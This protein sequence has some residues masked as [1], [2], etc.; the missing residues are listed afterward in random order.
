MKRKN[1]TILSIVVLITLLPLV[2]FSQKNREEIDEKYKWNLNDIYS[3]EEEWNTAKENLVNELP[4]LETFKGKLTSS[5]SDLLACLE[6]KTLVNKEAVKLYI[7]ASMNSDLDTRV[8]KYSG[9]K[10]E[11][12]QIFSEASAKLA[13]IQPELLSVDFSIYGDIPFFGE[14]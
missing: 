13:Y 4:K 5:A 8:A 9:M 14:L 11:L 3:S 6:L 2:S 7:Y 10:Q 1:F 12:Q